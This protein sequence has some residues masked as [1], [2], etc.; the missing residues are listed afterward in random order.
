MDRPDLPIN[1]G[2]PNKGRARSEPHERA[3]HSERLSEKGSDPLPLKKS[4]PVCE[5]IQKSV[6]YHSLEDIYCK[7]TGVP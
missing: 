4:R 3:F 7:W 6:R 5:P 1:D 2:E